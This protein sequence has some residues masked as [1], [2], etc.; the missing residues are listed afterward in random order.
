[1]KRRAGRILKPKKELAFKFRGVR[2]YTKNLGAV[3]QMSG[4]FVCFA[5]GNWTHDSATGVFSS[6]VAAVAD[7]FN[8]W[9]HLGLSYAPRFREP[10]QLVALAELR[11]EIASAMKQSRREYAEK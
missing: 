2:F 10:H 8:I 1:M 6:I 4:R 5:S 7:R 11:S 3:D 9:E